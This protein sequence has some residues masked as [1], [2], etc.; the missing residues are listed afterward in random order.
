M[1]QYIAFTPD[2]K[3]RTVIEERITVIENDTVRCPKCG[4]RL[5][6]E[7]YGKPTHC[8]VLVIP[9]KRTHIERKYL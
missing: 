6:K 2:G 3:I 1:K 7:I 8:G 5:D 9:N 4:V